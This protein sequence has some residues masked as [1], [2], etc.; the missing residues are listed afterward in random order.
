MYRASGLLEV[1][2]GEAPWQLRMLHVRQRGVD[3]QR[4]S[5]EK[6]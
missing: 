5:F 4:V 2:D 6:L 3:F 1:V